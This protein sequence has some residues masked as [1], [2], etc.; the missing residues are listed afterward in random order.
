MEKAWKSLYS[1]LT[2]KGN[3]VTL[4]YLLFFVLVWGTAFGGL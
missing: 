4:F 1:S 2:F 3:A